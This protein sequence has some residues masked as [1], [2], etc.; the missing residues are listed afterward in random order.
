MHL[1]VSAEFAKPSLT[2]IIMEADKVLER[3]LAID[4]G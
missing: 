3:D 4:A 2:L 1:N